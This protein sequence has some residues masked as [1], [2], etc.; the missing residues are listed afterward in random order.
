MVPRRVRYTIEVFNT[1]MHV[2]AMARLQLEI[3]LRQAID[4][5]EFQLHYQPFV[6]LETGRITGFET[7]LRWKHR[8]RGIV[9]PAEFIPVAEET[10]LI[11]PFC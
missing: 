5:Q 11:V 2:R 10:G 7:L 8:D 3:Y 4:R 6:S 9:S 1:D